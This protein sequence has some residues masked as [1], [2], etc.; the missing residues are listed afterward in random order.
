MLPTDDRDEWDSQLLADPRVTHLWDANRTLGRWLADEQNIDL[1]ETGEIVWDAFLLFGPE[2]TWERAPS[3]PLAWGAPIV[4][5]MPELID[6]LRPL[7]QKAAEQ[8]ATPSAAR[9][10]PI[11]EQRRWVVVPQEEHVYGNDSSFAGR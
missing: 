3:Q 5:H 11:D 7:L 4:G 2:A 10:V 9:R 8:A 6:T 1:G